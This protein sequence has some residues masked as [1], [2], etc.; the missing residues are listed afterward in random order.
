[1]HSKIA[2]GLLSENHQVSEI[3]L[4][5]LI[6]DSGTMSVRDHPM[7]RRIRSFGQTLESEIF[8]LKFI[9]QMDDELTGRQLRCHLLIFL[10]NLHQ[11]AT[12]NHDGENLQRAERLLSYAMKQGDQLD[13]YFIDVLRHQFSLSKAVR[14]APQPTELL[15]ANRIA[16]LKYG[17]HPK[18]IEVYAFMYARYFYYVIHSVSG[19]L[20]DEMLG[21]MKAFINDFE[22]RPIFHQSLQFNTSGLAELPSYLGEFVKYQF[23]S[24][25]SNIGEKFRSDPSMVTKMRKD[26]AGKVSGVNMMSE[27]NE[28]KTGTITRLLTGPDL[29]AM[30]GG[31]SLILGSYYELSKIEKDD[32]QIGKENLKDKE[33]QN[34]LDTINSADEQEKF[35][36]FLEKN[37]EIDDRS[38]K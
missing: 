26:M 17:F 1:M 19:K 35:L 9:E 7:E 38:T 36:D 18:V 12:L 23:A 33:L 22:L 30:L 5:N 31:V 2:E 13:Q 11:I 21:K 37:Q 27:L 4:Q 32:Q 29:Y 10:L 20:Q 28:D 8:I 24:S 14:V 25:P 3:T 16:Q 15:A 6:A 34:L